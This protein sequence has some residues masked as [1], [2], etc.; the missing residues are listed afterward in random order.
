MVTPIIKE[1][2]AE[3]LETML[4]IFHIENLVKM[5]KAWLGSVYFK[6]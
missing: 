4:V 2:S 5:I 1:R 3:T 6:K